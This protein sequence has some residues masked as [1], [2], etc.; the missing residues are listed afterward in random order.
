MLESVWQINVA[1]LLSEMLVCSTVVLPMPGRWR[2]KILNK[3]S[4]F[5]NRYPR[6]R[7]V[8]KT[9]IGFVALA[10]VDC[11]RTL[12]LMTQVSDPLNPAKPDD[13]KIKLYGAQRDAFI[14]GFIL[15][16]FLMLHRFERLVSNVAKLEKQYSEETTQQQDI[17]K[18]IEVLKQDKEKLLKQARENNLEEF[19]KPKG[20]SKSVG[21]P[22]STDYSPVPKTR[23]RNVAKE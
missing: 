2:K 3:L 23:K 21:A 9:L 5:W 17:K 4:H 18:E 16:L 12:Y 11:L 14:T 10:L 1:L 15:F 20:L 6:V 8:I 22:A 13:V 7:I 19:E